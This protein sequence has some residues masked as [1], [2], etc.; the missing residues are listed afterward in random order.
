MPTSKINFGKETGNNGMRRN[1]GN[2]LLTRAY[3][4]F[5]DNL[6]LGEYVIG[7]QK[8]R[9]KSRKHRFDSTADITIFTPNTYTV[10]CC[11]H[12]N[13]RRERT[14]GLE[15]QRLLATYLIVPLRAGCRISLAQRCRISD[16]GA[17][18]GRTER[19]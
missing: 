5:H 16:H 12:C 1:K 2:D 10:S 13:Q 7:P 4:I 8:D 18:L 14:G 9:I 6:S 3:S 11:T 19:T 15:S 17:T